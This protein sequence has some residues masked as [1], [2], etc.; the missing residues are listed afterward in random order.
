MIRNWLTIKRKEHTGSK[1]QQ[2][3]PNCVPSAS[4]ALT[5]DPIKG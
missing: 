2:S 1:E 3:N 4:H 5:F